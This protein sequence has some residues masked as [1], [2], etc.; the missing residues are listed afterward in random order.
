[1]TEAQLTDADVLLKWQLDPIAFVEE[2]LGVDGTDPAGIVISK[3]QRELLET[4]GAMVRAKMR[5]KLGKRMDDRDRRLA[6]KHGISVMAGR[7]CGKD[8][9]LT[10]LI[11][12]FLFCW[13]RAL[14]PCTAPTEHQL[15]QVL[16][17]NIAI[18]IHFSDQQQQRRGVDFRLSQ[19][20]IWR[21]SKVYH[22]LRDGKDW[23]ALPITVASKSTAEEQSIT[24]QGL[25]APFMLY[26]MDEAAGIPDGVCLAAEASLTEPI[27][28]IVLIFNPNKLRCYAVETHTTQKREFWECL[29][30]NTEECEFVTPE[31]IEKA[32]KE[33]GRESNY[34]RVNILGLPPKA[35]PDCLIPF[36]WID[37]AAS[38]E[39]DLER[40]DEDVKIMSIDVAGKGRDSTI[41]MCG[42]TG[43]GGIVIDE[44]RSFHSLDTEQVVNWAWGQAL[45]FEPDVVFVDANGIGFGV[46]SGLRRRAN[47][48]VIDIIAQ[49]NSDDPKCWH[50]VDELW[51]A[52]R[53]AF[54]ERRIKI[55]RNDRLMSQLGTPKMDEPHQGLFVVESNKKCKARGAGSLDEAS[56]LT[57]FFALPQR[58]LSSI[59]KGQT[60]RARPRRRAASWRVA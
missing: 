40:H 20:L 54:E 28:F 36:D 27:N 37:Y 31:T 39:C 35:D 1:M 17:R 8:V 50:K 26:A 25:H 48:N 22:A 44:P 18:W 41:I 60:E 51:W 32:R 59:K 15:Q 11:L 49:Q 30:W 13:E 23:Y 42:T 45:D 3:Q 2:A 7:G 16:W 24:F 43:P 56:A 46:A 53:K 58:Y 57:F 29:R 21:A 4:A 6:M 47:L 38:D 34:Y 19:I 55:P 10:W 14:V 12:W 52:T 33:Y 9:A 5:L